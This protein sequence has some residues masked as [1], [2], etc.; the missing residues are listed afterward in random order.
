MAKKEFKKNL[1]HK[2]R[3]ELVDFVFKGEDPSKAFGYE[4][5]NKWR[6]IKILSWEIS[7][8]DD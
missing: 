8:K 6:D 3:R 2:T 5:S 1:M 7:V 4:K